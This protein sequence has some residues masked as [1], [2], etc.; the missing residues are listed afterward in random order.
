MLGGIM[1]YLGGTLNG[2]EVNGPLLVDL[3]T[4]IAN[5]N[6]ALRVAEMVCPHQQIREE[7]AA[8]QATLREFMGLIGS[9]ER[10]DA[11]AHRAILQRALDEGQ[12]VLTRFLDQSAAAVYVGMKRYAI[13]TWTPKRLLA[14]SVTIEGR[15]HADPRQ[16][17]R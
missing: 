11:D 14:R 7:I 10:V 13:R 8:M 12:S 3:S 6:R 1:R 5:L 16:I 17:T 2:A 4:A 9:R 15:T